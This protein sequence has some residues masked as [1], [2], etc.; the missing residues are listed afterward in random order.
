MVV[1]STARLQVGGDELCVRWWGCDGCV[2][3][4]RTGQPRADFVLA[5]I[6]L[7]STEEAAPSAT[8]DVEEPDLCPLNYRS[9]P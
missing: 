9:G 1:E 7:T 5:L 3:G 6:A 2:I 8:R 4:H